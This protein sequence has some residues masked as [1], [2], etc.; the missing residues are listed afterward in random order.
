MTTLT[1]KNIFEA[2][3]KTGTSRVPTLIKKAKASCTT[4]YRWRHA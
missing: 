1:K 4:A 2:L 3:W